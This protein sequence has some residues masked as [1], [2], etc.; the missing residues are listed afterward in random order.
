MS[1]R[2]FL[3]WTLFIVILYVKFDKFEEQPSNKE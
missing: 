2:E 1:P 3:A